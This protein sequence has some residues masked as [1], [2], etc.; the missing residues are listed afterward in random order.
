MIAGDEYCSQIQNI[1]TWPP[2]FFILND[3]RILPSLPGE[4]ND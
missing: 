3:N 2:A 1:L 4:L